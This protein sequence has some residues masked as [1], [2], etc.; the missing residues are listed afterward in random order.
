MNSYY[1]RGFCLSPKLDKPLAACAVSHFEGSRSS[2]TSHTCGR[3]G[4]GLTMEALWRQQR[5]GR[6]ACS[7]DQ[8]GLGYHGRE[9]LNDVIAHFGAALPP[10][11]LS[12]FYIWDAKFTNLSL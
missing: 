9:G 10:V 2:M 7:W 4:H 1:K 6:W 12:A 5:P 11:T 3:A 8:D